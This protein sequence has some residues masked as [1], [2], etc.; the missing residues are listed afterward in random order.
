M[1]TPIKRPSFNA[2]PPNRCGNS[3]LIPSAN[4]LIWPLTPLLISKTFLGRDY[5]T[6]TAALDQLKNTVLLNQPWIKLV[7]DKLS[8]SFVFPDDFV[9]GIQLIRYCASILFA[10]FAILF[11]CRAT[12]KAIF[13]LCRYQKD[14]KFCNDDRK[15]WNSSSDH[16]H[17][18]RPMSTFNPTVLCNCCIRTRC[19]ETFIQQ[20]NTFVLSLNANRLGS[21]SKYNRRHPPVPFLRSRHQQHI[22]QTGSRRFRLCNRS[23][24]PTSPCCS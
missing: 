6:F 4:P 2:Q 18:P 20:C 8:V 10:S 15:C 5:D 14:F 16:Q 13:F 24:S 21:H 7:T 23:L 1:R 9:N 17:R 3:S 11:I 12:R 19:W 22:L